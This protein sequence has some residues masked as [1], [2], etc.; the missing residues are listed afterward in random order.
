M[1]GAEKEIINILWTGGLDST[2]RICDLS[3]FD[4]TVQPYYIVESRA[5][6]KYERRAMETIAELL[7]TKETTKFDLLPVRF[8]ESKTFSA[9][10]EVTEAFRYLRES[11]R[12]G[13]QYDYLARFLKQYG[14]KA[15]FCFVGTSGGR[16]GRVFSTEGTLVRRSYFPEAA[17]EQEPF[18]YFELD[19]DASSPEILRVFENVRIPA[20]TWNKEKTYEYD[21]LVSWGMEDI[22][23]AT[24]FCHSP[25]FG[26]PCG[27]CNPCKDALNEGL[28]WRVPYHG[29]LRY[30][31]KA[32]DYASLCCH[33]AKIAKIIGNKL[34]R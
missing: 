26:K 24:W 14:L 19:P 18:A 7:K 9:D 5:S 30:L 6:E 8:I 27:A 20:S 10:P 33:P 31:R 13:T 1:A 15:E 28:A 3:R 11:Y 23:K 25:V 17:A 21:T 32:F 4:V 29:N 34:S 2:F 12:L 16:I 22:A